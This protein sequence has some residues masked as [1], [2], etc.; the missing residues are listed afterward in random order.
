MPIEIKGETFRSVE[1]YAYQRLVETLKLGDD[2]I[3][4][5]R[6]TVKPA[7]LSI[8]VK[9]IVRAQRLEMPDVLAKMKK[10]YRWRQ[11][12]IRN[13]FG[14]HEALQQLLLATGHAILL[15]NA[16]ADDRRWVS[17]ADEVGEEWMR[18]SQ[19]AA[20]TTLRFWT[21]PILHNFLPRF[22]STRARFS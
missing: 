18:P 13:K 20:S 10:M 8:A 21:E 6:T 5:L 9:R 16:D 17:N 11:T 19:L 2:E 1:H 22:K 7:D 12:A 4:K 15:E 14:K 3:M